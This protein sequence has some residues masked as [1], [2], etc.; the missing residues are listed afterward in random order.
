M[1]GIGI[2]LT[3]FALA[4]MCCVAG[5]ATPS[6]ATAA[7]PFHVSIAEAKYNAETKSLEI[8]LRVHPSDLETMLRKRTDKPIDLDKTANVD[9]LILAYLTDV[10][11]AKPKQDA[12]PVKLK[13]VGKQIDIKYAWLY[14]ECPLPDGM[15]GVELSNKIFFEIL[16]DQVNTITLTDGEFKQSIN[17]TRDKPATVVEKNAAEKA[18][19]EKTAGK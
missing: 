14:F 12:E 4:A 13:W 3:C 19:V 1:I 6:S 2:R 7:H 10:F 5:L 17:C 8:A 18:V 11:T 16:S 9:E 15:P